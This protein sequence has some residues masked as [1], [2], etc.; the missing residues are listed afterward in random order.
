MVVVEKEYKN[1]PDDMETI[2]MWAE[3]SSSNVADALSG[4]G[5]SPAID[6]RD[7]IIS[8]EDVSKIRKDA[9]TAI[10]NDAPAESSSW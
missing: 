8:T 7:V 1:S 3:K 10:R 9:E 4:K 5:K 6:A 2:T